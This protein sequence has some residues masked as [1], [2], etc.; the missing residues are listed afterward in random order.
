M[1]FEQIIL[2]TFAAPM[3]KFWSVWSS[4]DLKSAVRSA[5][6]FV[7][8]SELEIPYSVLFLHMV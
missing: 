7:S 1:V 5:I 8:L 6:N 2:Q 3:V 4:F